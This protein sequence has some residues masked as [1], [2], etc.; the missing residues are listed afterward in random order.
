[1]HQCLE[2][3]HKHL[4]QAMVVHEEEVPMGYPEHI[5]RVRGHFAEAARESVSHYPRLA[6]LLR[7]WRRY[8][9]AEPF[10]A[11]P[12]YDAILD[13][14]EAL[15]ALDEEGTTSH[16]VHVFMSDEDDKSPEIPG[17]LCPPD[18]E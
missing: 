7:Q 1:M 18:T 17:D 8:L 9:L 15:V 6:N 5:R 16:R 10:N 11:V 4:E 3:V 2:C 14:V 13:Y 12:P